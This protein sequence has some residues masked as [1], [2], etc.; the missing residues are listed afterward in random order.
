MSNL[1][2]I[3]E[4]AEFASQHIKKNV[5][6]SNI[7]YLL[8]YGRVPKIGSNGSVLVKQEDLVRYYESYYGER[9]ISWKDALGDDLNWAL[10][11]DYLKESDATKH[12]HRLHPYKGKFIPHFAAAQYKVGNSI[13]HGAQEEIQ[14]IINTLS[15]SGSPDKMSEIERIREVCRSGSMNS[16]RT[17]KV[18]LFLQS[19]NGEIFLFDLKTAKPNISSFKDFKRTLLEWIG[20]VLAES[21]D[22]KIVSYIAIPYNPYHP[23]PYQRWTLKRMLDLPQEL[24][25]AEEF[26][27]FLGG[28]NIYNDLLD[29]F[30]KAGIAMRT[31]IDDYF[32]KFQTES[33]EIR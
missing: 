13:S 11:F 28:E 18:D 3:K 32:S 21:P 15:I 22:A 5:P 25:V 30:E 31:E 16:L 9:E 10:S 12:V 6:A 26:W 2:T 20:I 7:S 4:A 19:I 14:Q 27:D 17:V 8:N 23:A 33:H 24:K 1:L 29:C